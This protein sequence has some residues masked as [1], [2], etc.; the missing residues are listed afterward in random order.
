MILASHIQQY[1]GQRIHERDGLVDG[2]P[3]ELLKSGCEV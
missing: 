3:P 2:E 1:D